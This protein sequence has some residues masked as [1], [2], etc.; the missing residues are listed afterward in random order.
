MSGF[1]WTTDTGR[2]NIDVFYTMPDMYL[3]KLKAGFA[4]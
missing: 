4:L 2:F 3:I 1:A